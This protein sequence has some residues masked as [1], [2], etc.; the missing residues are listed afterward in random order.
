MLSVQIFRESVS[1]KRWKWLWLSLALGAA[2]SRA[3]S[4]R[5]FY[6]DYSS[7][8]PD[9]AARL[10]DTLIVHPEA[11]IDLA[12][13]HQQ[14][15][16]ALAYLSIGEVAADA[17][18]RDEVLQKK[19]PF[20]GRNPIWN[21]DLIDLTDKR[22]LDYLVDTLAADIVHKG[23]DGFFLDTADSVLTV[24]P[25]DV[26]RTAALRDAV[27]RLVRRLKTQFP[28]KQIV[29]NRGFFALEAVKSSLSGVLAESLYSTYDFNTAT[30]RAVPAEETASLL[31]ELRRGAANGLE[32]YVI[33]YVAPDD[34]TTA[35]RTAERI[36]Q[37]GFRA[38]VSTPDLRGHSLAPIRTVPRRICAFYG[39]LAQRPQDQINWPMESFVGRNLQTQLE[40]MG[41]ESDYFKIRTPADLPALDEHYRAI[42]LPNFWEIPESVE[43]AVVDW[44][45][46]QKAAG[47]KI[48]IFGTLPFNDEWALKKFLNAFDLRGTGKTIGDV[49]AAELAPHQAFHQDAE[50]TPT[51]STTGNLD[52]QAP[53]NAQVALQVTVTKADGTVV[54]FDAAFVCDWGGAVLNPY[55]FYNR[56]DDIDLWQFDSFG[57]LDAAVGAVPAPI[58]DTTTRDGLR[59]LMSHIDGDGFANVSWTDS[60][61]RSAEVVRDS[62]L[63]RYPMPVTVSVIEAEIRCL[64]VGQDPADQSHLEKIAREIFALPNVQPA[65]HSFSHPFVWVDGDPSG[66]RYES[67]NLELKT[68]Y[69][70]NYE[71]EIDGSVDYINRQLAAPGRPVEVFLWSGNCR[72][73]PEALARV[74]ELGLINV[75]GGD[76]LISKRYPT[77]TKVAPRTMPWGNELQVFAPNQ[78]ENV[79]TNNWEG[80]LYGTFIHVIDSFKRTE[81]P[82]R[83]K[84]VDIYYHFYSA[85]YHA[86]LRALHTIYD[87]AMAQ[88]LHSVT[89]RDYALMAIDARNTTIHQ[90]GP[91]HWRILTGGHLRTLRLPAESANRIDL[92]RSRG[93][94]GWNQTGDVAYVHTDGSAEIEIRLADQPIPN[95]PRLQ[96]STANLTFERFT[97]EA[98]VFK[99]RDLRPATVILAGLPAGIELIALINGQTEAVSTAADGTL[100]LTL[101][102]VAETRL[103]LPR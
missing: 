52:L 57:F 102:A 56:A 16:V 48:L 75:N 67:H 54:R 33:D 90:V 1:F 55:L 30:Y 60:S 85:D 99:T 49:A 41:Y 31:R 89:L 45:I 79:Y 88:P 70:M 83:L 19:L 74:R 94:T 61:K 28:D 93:V 58:P 87:W 26:E 53:D 4:P 62:I 12:K 91:E 44:L 95:Q 64:G 5:A 25:D 18:Y 11:Q 100:T 71:R 32:V 76:T 37:A 97:P 72:P 39:N 27:V 40:W 3:E 38:F 59:M 65:S 96:S 92:N 101:P 9:E 73:G 69:T 22:W 78:N 82:R 17:H 84:P 81:T 21:S 6:V 50:A 24:A 47:R 68:P 14:N 43:P 80:P 42:V 35:I 10:Y 29:L 7:V 51:A 34:P 36:E 13:V 63:T 66:M 23:F 46:T 2:I 77:L 98:L 20:A 86:S 8:I 103:E 15:A